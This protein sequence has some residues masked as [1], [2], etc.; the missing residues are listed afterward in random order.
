MKNNKIIYFLLIAIIIAGALFVNPARAADTPPS[1]GVEIR[2]IDQESEIIKKVDGGE[3]EP[4]NHWVHYNGLEWS[5]VQLDR[6]LDPDWSVQHVTDLKVHLAHIDTEGMEVVLIIRGTPDWA[7]NN[8]GYSCGPIKSTDIDAFAEFVVEAA[9]EFDFIKYFEIWNEPDAT[10]N[11]K[12]PDSQFGCWGNTT[13]DYGGGQYYGRVLEAVYDAVQQA[14]TDKKISP[15]VKIL[16]GGLLLGYDSDY[17]HAQKN[18]NFFEGILK[19]CGGGNSCFD[20]VNFHGYTFY[21]PNFNP[22]RLEKD[23]PDWLF[24]NNKGGQVEGKLAYLLDLLDAYDVNDKQIFLTEAALIDF[25]IPDRPYGYVINDYDEKF[26]SAKADYVVWLYTR[27]L[28]LGI[29]ATF[30]YQ[31]DS[32][33]WNQS[34]LLKRKTNNNAPLPAYHAYAGV[35]KALA[36]VSTDNFLRGGNRY[37]FGPGVVGYEINKS[38]GPYMWVLFT[39]GGGGMTVHFDEGIT[40][41]VYDRDYELLTG[42]D[43]FYAFD[44]PVYIESTEMLVPEENDIV[45]DFHTGF[46][47]LISQ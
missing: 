23:N 4:N 35:T 18:D 42:V 27:N 24:W 29:D 22:I 3:N 30:W 5:K 12:K 19:H 40:A 16:N 2:D 14:I 34:G 37:S 33:G 44:G 45:I 39:S 38:D 26:E 17:P 36:G 28:A 13:D 46:L 43:G 15:D 11:P 7:Q 47:P 21:K 1:F 9:Q 10:P 25:E 32:Y 31:L 6:N 8:A 41:D 20:I